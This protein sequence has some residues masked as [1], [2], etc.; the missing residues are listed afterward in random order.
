MPLISTIRDLGFPLSSTVDKG[1]PKSRIVLIKGIEDNGVVFYTNYE[2]DKGV[3]MEHNPNVSICFFWSELE[4]QVRIEGRAEK[5]SREESKAYFESRPLMSQIGAWT[6][7][8]SEIIE[9]REQLEAKF[10]ELKQRFADGE[11]PLPDYWGGYYVEPHRFEFWQGRAS[12]LHDRICYEKDGESWNIFR[13][14][15]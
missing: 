7:N 8:Q 9:N 13:L 2:S 12:R 6:S 1:K 11:V 10:E 4:R 3:E 15:P 14:S 5:I